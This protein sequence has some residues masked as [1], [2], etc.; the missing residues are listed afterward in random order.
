MK[1]PR[2]AVCR[3]E[4]FKRYWDGV[5]DT[6]RKFDPEPRIEKWEQEDPNFEDEYIL[7][8]PVRGPGKQPQEVNPFDFRWDSH[9]IIT[10]L[11]VKRVRFASYDGQ[12]VGGLL[13]QP[14]YSR[15]EHFPGIVHFA[16]YGGEVLIDSDFVSSGYSVFNFSHRGMLLGSRNFDRYSPTPLL[17]R[18][19]EDPDRYIYRSIVIDS[20][21]ALKAMAKLGNVDPRRVAVLGTSQGGALAVITAA[22]DAQVRAAACDLPWLTDF[23]YLV[24]HPLEG[25]N[26]ELKEF[27]T[28]FPEKANAAARTLGYFDAL[29]FAEQIEKPVL[30]SLGQEDHL[31]PPPAVRKLFERIPSVKLLL[32]IPGMGHERSTLFRNLAQKWFDF[33]V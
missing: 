12:E 6:V 17:V 24:E 1:E 7:D 30:M 8:G 22:L 16:G 5:L 15:K 11:T 3:P 2:F 25:P 14:R 9:V 26:N 28:R 32:E 29:S 18:H 20:L 33:F 23:E 4:D 10:G 21:L 27:L 13:Q 19:I 31:A